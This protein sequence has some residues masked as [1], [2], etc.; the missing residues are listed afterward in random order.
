MR[1]DG[2]TCAQTYLDQESGALVLRRLH[3]RIASYNDVVV[4]LMKSNM[5]IKFI[6]SGEAAKALLY[7]ITDYITKPSL[8]VHIGLGALSYA[9][10]R[11]NE[12]YPHIRNDSDPSESKG[13]LTMT[14]NRMMSRQ[15]VSHQQV[16]SYLVGGGDNYCSHTFR[17]LH[18]GAFD[19]LFK[20]AFPSAADREGLQA[21]NLVPD[22]EN[23]QTYILTM[24]K[25]SISA[26]NQQQDY[27]LRSKDAAF[28]QLCLYDFVGLTEKMT[29]GS[30]LAL[31]VGSTD[32][33]NR[34]APDLQRSRIAAPHGAFCSKD[35]T[36]FNTHCLRL[37]T[38]WT[39][40]VL[41]GDRT[42]RSDRGDEE[43]DMWARMMSILFIP[44]RNPSDLRSPAESWTKA[45]ERHQNQLSDQHRK[46]IANMNVLSECRDVRDEFRDLRRAEALASMRQGIVSGS[47]QHTGLDDEN[48]LQDFQLFDRPDSG[49][50]Y[51]HSNKLEASQATLDRTL[52]EDGRAVI[53]LCYGSADKEVSV[54]QEGRAPLRTNSWREHGAEDAPVLEQ[55]A[56]TMR[57]LKKERRPRVSG[58]DEE[59]PRKRRRTGDTEE[60]MTQASLSC[61]GDDPMEV[62]GDRTRP[63]GTQ[64]IRAA[65]EL[66][67][68]EMDLSS[69]PEQERAFRIVGEHLY[70]GNEQLLMYIAGVGGTGKTH[71]VRAILRLFAILNR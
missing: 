6:G 54:G 12:K 55:Q 1:I 29:K 45:F 9:I 26:M 68:R 71:V 22:D 52:G 51:G 32:V 53:D 34:D 62:E 58:E 46:I 16:M 31:G 38:T 50:V 56:T 65:I 10:Q 7:Y 69:N 49:D 14:V 63:D 21:G 37:R 44:W 35:H 40:P 61:I 28:E 24:G 2:S 4:F 42:P 41:L 60:N 5:D 33:K 19:R 70:E 17:V 64:P 67:V 39:V 48:M 59:R 20:S 3:P 18:W 25:G 43:K 27:R 11:T 30:K 15:E 47:N 13:A 23:G 57:A 8:P 36:Q 66:V